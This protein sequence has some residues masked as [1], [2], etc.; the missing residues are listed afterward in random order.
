MT[1]LLN[2]SNDASR[3]T[4][5]FSIKNIEVSVDSEEQNWFKRAHVGKFLRIR[6]FG[7][8]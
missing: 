1:S 4:E 5:E 6:I 2:N 3:K 8:H 7:H